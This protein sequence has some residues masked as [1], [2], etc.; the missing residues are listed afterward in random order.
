VSVTNA[1]TKNTKNTKDTKDTMA[2][3][4]TSLLARELKDAY[5]SRTVITVPPSARDASFDL[6]AAYAVEAELARLRREEGRVSVGR[7]VGYA[8]KAVWRALKLETVAWANMYDDTVR[9][10]T[11]NAALLPLGRMTSPKIEP[12][13]V[14]KMKRPLNGDLHDPAAVLGAV[15]WIALGF[16]IIDCVYAEWKF[17]PSD[18]VASYGF[19]AALIVGEPHRVEPESIPTLVDQ[20][21]GFTV[22]LRRNGEVVAEG[23]GRNVL[24]SPALCVGE[25]ASAT[26]ARQDAEP[27]GAGEIISSGTLTESKPIAPGEEWS[28]IVDG[29]DLPP[30]TVRTTE[31]D[32]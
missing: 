14:F 30:L 19:H 8:N 24:R 31:Q 2:S 25:L 7:K 20:M 11:K 18:F 16:E 5:A 29:I 22:Q 23:S 10:A 13:I 26:A 12:E 32:L 21:A 27:L 6:T 9:H 28:A 4:D 1:N 17:Q 3:L 15:E